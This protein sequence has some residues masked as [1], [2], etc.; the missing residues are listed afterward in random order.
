[1][2]VRL[3]LRCDQRTHRPEDGNADAFHTKI[4][5]NCAAA[6]AAVVAQTAAPVD[7]DAPTCKAQSVYAETAGPPV[8]VRP[9][10]R[11]SK[12]R[13]AAIAMAI[14]SL[15][16]SD[17][18]DPDAAA[19]GNGGGVD[20]GYHSGGHLLAGSPPDSQL[21]STTGV[22][23]GMAAPL[24]AAARGPS[25]PV[26]ATA[27]MVT[28]PGAGGGGVGGGGGT[29]PTVAIGAAS[30]RVVGGTRAVVG[31]APP[32]LPHHLLAG[33]V[34][35]SAPKAKP[36]NRSTSAVRTV[37]ASGA[38]TGHSTGAGVAWLGAVTAIP[39]PEARVGHAVGS[40][41]GGHDGGHVTV[42][43]LP[44]TVVQYGVPP[45]GDD[46]SGDDG[47]NGCELA[48][49]LDVEYLQADIANDLLAL[50]PGLT[51]AAAHGGG[52]TTA[53]TGRRKGKATRTVGYAVFG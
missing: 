39:R 40:T 15:C 30:V 42:M 32:P 51:T 23:V 33:G 37:S 19:Q 28:A 5:P 25:M 26:F 14:P 8:D 48:V 18:D 7:V 36:R 27:S 24:H 13:V 11:A 43:P 29:T 34:A 2:R 53:R 21:L 12:K 35:A 20:G 46:R 4:D 22:P 45:V 6:T 49:G 47:D 31:H 16:G 50:A 1:M 38:A 52:S 9:R 3:R 17:G 41:S 44:T 10:R